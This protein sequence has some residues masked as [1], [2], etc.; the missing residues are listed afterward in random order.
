MAVMVNAVADV[1]PGVKPGA[2][3][4]NVRN[5]ANPESGNATNQDFDELAAA[6]RASEAAPKILERAG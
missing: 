5:P 6:A 1:V 2:N 3:K 4:Q